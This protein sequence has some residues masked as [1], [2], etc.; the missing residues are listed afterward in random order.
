MSENN[1]GFSAYHEKSVKTDFMR[2]EENPP[3]LWNTNDLIYT[4]YRYAY[5][6]RL[7]FVF[8]L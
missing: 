1:K 7:F 5:T 4:Y 8:H 2:Y 6:T 3:N